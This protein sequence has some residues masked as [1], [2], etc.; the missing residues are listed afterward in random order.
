MCDTGALFLHDCPVERLIPIYL[1]VGGSVALFANMAGFV[2]SICYH[3]DPDSEWRCLGYCCSVLQ[4][5]I[6]CFMFAWF[7]AGEF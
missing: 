1:L 5:L 7:I 2:Q 3:K 6:S 4:S